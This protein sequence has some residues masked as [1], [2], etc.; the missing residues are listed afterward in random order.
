MRL[1]ILLTLIF[2]IPSTYAEKLI[3]GT[4]PFS[5]PFVMASDG[6]EHYI[7]FS[8]DIMSAICKQ[9]EVTCLYKSIGFE[10]MFTEVINGSVDLAIGSITITPEREQYLLFSLPY[11][12]SE[13]EFLTLNNSPITSISELKGRILGAE[14]DSVFIP[15]IEKNYGSDVQIKTYRSISEMMLGLSQ[16]EVDAV[17]FD[18]ETAEF[19]HANNNDVYKFIGAPIPL[20]LGIGIITNKSNGALM[21][22][23]NKALLTMQSEGIYL[24]IYNTYFGD[25]TQ[26]SRSIF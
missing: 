24:N 1:L 5:P 12:Q 16:S 19:W 14:H 15:F 2:V 22:R 3:I 25:M 20:G 7:G 10:Q 26:V 13:L 6:K 11:L 8:I 21:A 18:K 9:M 17:I 4:P 23:V